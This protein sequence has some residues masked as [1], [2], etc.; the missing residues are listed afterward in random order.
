MPPVRPTFAQRGLHDK[1]PHL[2]KQPHLTDG[3]TIG[4]ARG[5]QQRLVAHL[6]L[7]V[8]LQQI[9]EAKQ[10]VGDRQQLLLRQLELR[11]GESPQ[12][13]Q[14]QDARIGLSQAV[15]RDINYRSQQ[16]TGL[17]LLQQQI[18]GGGG[19]A[20]L[21]RVLVLQQYQLDAGG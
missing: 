20:I 21:P 7:H 5:Q 9:A 14:G 18:S 12:Q 10:P 6:L 2:T 16:P 15:R 19:T 11:H 1:S 17:G 8:V 4:H 13:L 3:G